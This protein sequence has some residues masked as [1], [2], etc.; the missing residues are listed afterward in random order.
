MKQE[1]YGLALRNEISMCKDRRMVQIVNSNS[2]IKE[3]RIHGS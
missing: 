2:T 3:T 1:A